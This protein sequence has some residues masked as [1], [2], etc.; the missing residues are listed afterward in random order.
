[1]KA[2]IIGAGPAGLTCALK[3]IESGFNVD[4]YES[5]AAAGGMT[6]SFDLW[7]QRVDV[8]PH[9]F[10]SMDEKINSFW[11]EQVGE[12]YVMVDRLTRI[13]YNKK[14]F[15]YPVKAMNALKNLGFIEAMS[16]VLSYIKACF[17]KKGSEKTFEEWVSHKFGYKL[18]NVFFKTYS[19]RLWGISCKNLDADFARQRIK[20]LDLFEVIKSAI[21]Q[22]KSVKHKTLV[23]QFAYPKMGAGVPYDNIVKKIASK[24]GNKI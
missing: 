5:S 3:L 14:F 17:A 4:V 24:G 13:Y 2:A 22:Q 11:R 23:E 1:M 9:R 19:E 16:C 7:G 18:Y 20:G 21:F 6:K 12:D 8:G 10:F 15:L